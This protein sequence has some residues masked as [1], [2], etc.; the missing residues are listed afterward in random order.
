MARSRLTTP[1]KL[2]LVPLSPGQK[3]PRFPQYTIPSPPPPTHSPPSSRV[4]NRPSNGV[5]ISIH[6]RGASEGVL[7]G[8]LE[9]RAGASLTRRQP[10]NVCFTFRRSGR[11]LWANETTLRKAS[12]YFESL[13]SSAFY[14]GKAAP[15]PS[16][17]I[18]VEAGLPLYTY[19]E[20]DDERDDALL[21][22][23][24]HEIP[25]SS[26]PCKIV[27]VIDTAYSTYASVSTS[28]A[29][30]PRLLPPPPPVSP[31][32]V[33]RLAHLLELPALSALALAN[34]KSQ[35]GSVNA[36]AE[37]YS[38]MAMAYDAGKALAMDK[39]VEGWKEVK[40]SEAL[41]KVEKARRGEVG[42]EVAV[43]A[44]ELARRLMERYG[45]K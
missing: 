28:S 21:P 4:G 30:H 34:L 23:V 39:V 40:E 19:D 38:D 37:L 32:S 25:D 14:E 15:L 9:S 36:A 16:S 20:S 31:K 45:P 33:Y 22:A 44:M 18:Q 3:R 17:S 13:L 5:T 6:A 2:S 11:L 41:R 43:T 26:S 27:R 1:S 7:A 42:S 10:N 12:P 35:L 29:S 8:E 24:K